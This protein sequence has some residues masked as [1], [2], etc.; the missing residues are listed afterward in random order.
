MPEIKQAEIFQGQM[1][2]ISE[3]IL[4][5][6]D[7]QLDM[8][9]KI[10]FENGLGRKFTKPENHRALDDIEGSIQELKWY[11]TFLK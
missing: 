3:M 6:T 5:N 4:S 10:Y 1:I 9:W 2:E 7:N 8:T 11:L